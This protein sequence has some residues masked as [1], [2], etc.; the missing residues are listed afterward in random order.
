MSLIK[1]L[2]RMIGL[3]EGIQSEDGYDYFPDLATEGGDE[4]I[5]TLQ[6]YKALIANL[7][8]CPDCMATLKI[9]DNKL[10]FVE[11]AI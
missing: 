8:Q 10:Q 7:Q 6:E 3:L 1:K 2:D 5:E 11:H 4:I 9:V